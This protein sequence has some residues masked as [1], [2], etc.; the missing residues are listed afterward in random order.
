[1]TI[2]IIDNTPQY[3]NVHF[4]TKCKMTTS[5]KNISIFSTDLRFLCAYLENFNFLV[6]SFRIHKSMLTTNSRLCIEKSF[7]SSNGLRVSI[8]IFNLL[9]LLWTKQETNHNFTSKK[10]CFLHLKRCLLCRLSFQ[11]LHKFL[12]GSCLYITF[13]Y[14]SIRLNTFVCFFYFYFEQRPLQA[15]LCIHFL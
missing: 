4:Q 7:P 11:H 14:L 9:T 8:V 1:M 12:I 6:L 10:S 13:T 3:E 5:R 2:I 15:I